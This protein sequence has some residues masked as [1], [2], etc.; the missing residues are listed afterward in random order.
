MKMIKFNKG[1]TLIELTV[2][3]AVIMILA[4]IAVPNFL[5]LPRQGKETCY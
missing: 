3:L 5:G 4:A 1:F 2:V